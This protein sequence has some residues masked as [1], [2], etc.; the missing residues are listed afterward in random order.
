MFFAACSSFSISNSR[1]RRSPELWGAR[2]VGC[3]GRR[4][5][6]AFPAAVA[7]NSAVALL[8]NHQRPRDVK[9]DQFV[10]EEV[11]VQALARDIGSEHRRTG[12]MVTAEFLDRSLQ[13]DI[14]NAGTMDNGYLIFAQSQILGEILFEETQCLDALGENDDAVVGLSWIPVEKAAWLQDFNQALVLGEVAGSNIFQSFRNAG[15]GNAVLV[16]IRARFLFDL[17]QALANCL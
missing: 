15:Q 12:G 9:M 2:G 7:V 1:M 3:R 11:E 14:L 17:S 5:A 16:S 8:K 13:V 4:C 6:A 10:T